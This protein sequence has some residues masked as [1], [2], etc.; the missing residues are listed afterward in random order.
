MLVRSYLP[1]CERS[2]LLCYTPMFH[3]RLYIG[4]PKYQTSHFEPTLERASATDVSTPPEQPKDAPHLDGNPQTDRPLLVQFC[5]N[6]SAV[7]CKAASHVAPYCDAVDLNLGCP[8][9]IAKKGRYGSFLQEDQELVHSLIKEVH[10]AQEQ[11]VPTP[12]TAK[13]RIL[14][15]PEKTLAYAKNVL[16]AGASILAVHGRRREQKGHL[17]GLADW[18]A[19]RRLREELPA[20]TVLFANG[21]VLTHEDLDR[22]LE[23]TGADGV[24]SAEGALSDPAIF[25]KP[26]PPG[27][28]GREYWRGRDGRG[29]WRVDGAMRRYVDI[30]WKYCTPCDPPSRHRL[31]IPGDCAP[32]FFGT[33][34][35]QEEG[36]VPRRNRSKVHEKK[37]RVTSPNLTAVQ[38]HLFSLLRH[39][40]TRHTLVRDMVAK[41]RSG[42][43]EHLESVLFE[44]EWKCAVGLKEY[45]DTNGKSWDDEEQEMDKETVA[46]LR[47]EHAKF[48]DKKKANEDMSTMREVV[49]EDANSSLQ[50]IRRCRRPWWVCQPVIRPLPKEALAIGSVKPKKVKE[51]KTFEGEENGSNGVFG[52]GDTSDLQ[53]VAATATHG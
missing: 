47:G 17:T 43:M 9:G 28:E 19:I 20:E 38:P 40:V 53:G 39:L 45:E 13:I 36:E 2:K 1:P 35:K 52:N 31:Y 46:K 41:L 44:V 22:C 8:Q 32:W 24:L 42:D 25:A 51:K 27:Q 15:T 18:G 16:S 21:N 14:D 11:F 30:L 49:H 5:A 29:G 7:F 50:A 34:P 48:G 6:D 23:A 37:S 4:D 12:V 33:E 3:A 10:R 26:P